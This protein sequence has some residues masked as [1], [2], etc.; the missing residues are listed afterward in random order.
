MI[1]IPDNVLEA[2]MEAEK[3]RANGPF[4]PA[5]KEVI[6][7]A[8]NKANVEIKQ[9]IMAALE[10]AQKPMTVSGL[11]CEI[12]TLRKINDGMEEY[13]DITAK[14]TNKVVEECV[15]TPTEEIDEVVE[16]CVDTPTEEINEVVEECVDV[17]AEEINE[18]VEE[19]VDVPAEQNSSKKVTIPY[20]KYTGGVDIVCMFERTVSKINYLVNHTERDYQIVKLCNPT[21]IRPDTFVAKVE[22]DSLVMVET[23]DL[24]RELVSKI[25]TRNVVREWSYCGSDGNLCDVFK[26]YLPSGYVASVCAV[27]VKDLPEQLYIDGK[28]KITPKNS[29]DWFEV[30]PTCEDQPPIMTNVKG[31]QFYNA[32]TIKVLK[33]DMTILNW[34]PGVHPCFRKFNHI[35][36]H[37]VI[38]G[39]DWNN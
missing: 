2:V 1:P 26:A 25:N 38:I 12:E 24:F 35:H 17:P 5:K 8:T 31:M 29:Y 28:V 23:L 9:Q 37:I 21:L 36:D 14:D 39:K 33:R 10:Y 15:D 20:K 16:E 13:V 19:C 7:A 22:G 6:N 27:A 32:I 18:V 34:M 30:Q 4:K 11:I 3:E